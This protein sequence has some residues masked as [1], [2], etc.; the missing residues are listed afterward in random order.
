MDSCQ[1]LN[2]LCARVTPQ[3]LDVSVLVFHL[4]AF[5]VHLLLSVVHLLLPPLLRLLQFPVQ[6]KSILKSIQLNNFYHYLYY[7]S[8]AAPLSFSSDLFV[9]NSY[10]HYIQCVQCL[11]CSGCSLSESDSWGSKNSGSSSISDS[12][13]E[14]NMSTTSCV[15]R[16]IACVVLSVESDAFLW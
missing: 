7:I 8:V 4:C 12:S 5:V 9:P 3:Q 11:P 15:V 14:S 16:A 6:T 2:Q 1:C 13:E 10:F